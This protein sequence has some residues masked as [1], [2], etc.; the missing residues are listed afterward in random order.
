VFTFPKIYIHLNDYIRLFIYRKLCLFRGNATGSEA[1]HVKDLQHAV[2]SVRRAYKACSG[3][4][5]NSVSW[6]FACMQFADRVTREKL[7][8]SCVVDKREIAVKIVNYRIW[9]IKGV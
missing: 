9:C 4:Q 8:Q 6:H 5:K 7:L 1:G 2:L 3:T